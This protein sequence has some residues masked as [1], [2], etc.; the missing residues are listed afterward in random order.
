MKLNNEI[1]SDYIS[2]F[3][4]KIVGFK[5]QVVK[6]VPIGQSDNEF[7]S[8]AMDKIDRL[9]RKSGRLRVRVWSN[10]YFIFHSDEIEPSKSYKEKVAAIKRHYPFLFIRS[11]VYFI[12]VD[13]SK[14][15]QTSIL[16][17]PHRE[18][19]TKDY[20]IWLFNSKY[21][22]QEETRRSNLF[23]IALDE[24]EVIDD[25]IYLANPD[26]ELQRIESSNSDAVDCVRAFTGDLELLEQ[27]SDMLDVVRSEFDE[28]PIARIIL[29]GPA[30]SG[31]TIIAATLLGEYKDSKFLLMNYFFYQAIV[32]GFHALSGWSAKEIEQLVKNPEIDQLLSLKEA[33]PKNL[34]KIKEN[35]NYAIRECDNPW[36][37]SKTKQWLMENI[38]EF[39]NGFEKLGFEK[40]DLF[41]FSSLTNLNSKL[42]NTNNEA[43]FIGIDRNNLLKLKDQIDGLV[44]GKYDS[45]RNLQAIVVET[46]GELIRNSKQRFF[47]HNIN[48]NISSKIKDGCWIN[49]GDPTSS[50]MW[51]D[52][53]RPKLIICDEVQRLGL[54]PEYGNY[55]EFDEVKQVLIHSDQSFFTGDNYQMLNSKYDQGIE[56]ISNAIQNKGQSLTKLTLPESVGVPAEIGILMKYL[57][58]PQAVSVETVVG[59]WEEDR[60]FEIIFIE[61][62]VNQLIT[63]LDGDVSNKK[64]LASPL[65]YS[66][67]EYEET[68]QI[69]TLHRENPIIPLG[70]HEK[71]D[72]AYKFPYFCNEEI[73]SNYILSA[74]E[75][76]SREVESLYVHIPKFK[77]MQSEHEEW[78][79]KHLYVLFTR[80]TARLVVNYD[81]K[82]D[83]ERVKKMIKV[84]QGNGAKISTSFFG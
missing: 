84:L 4:S 8:I 38:E 56:R 50:K 34:K 77:K 51:T 82:E 60:D 29:E 14:E 33:M 20:K 75:L 18:I 66:W 65:D 72:F 32:D 67:L 11:Y 58:N 79:R 54:I 45:I 3:F 68:I 52:D 5:S 62:N 80:P 21:E 1:V 24:N 59:Y 47:H 55:D 41:I 61:S 69:D 30:R 16:V 15:K 63:F 19:E 28:N 31:K 26:S 39:K 44:S 40:K 13:I 25:Y 49:R 43:P 36:P 83:F 10:C 76:I 71:K 46:I 48:K 81:V 73:M 57:T 42:I 64:H 70:S 2:Y 9:T 74:Y 27:T 12:F 7:L 53:Y 22:L 78:Y 35:L 23:G 17:E 6:Y 37:G